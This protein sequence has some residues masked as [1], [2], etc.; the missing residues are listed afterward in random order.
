M[1]MPN[2]KK[3][4]HEK[5]KKSKHTQRDFS[6][7]PLV[8]TPSFQCREHEF[9]LWVISTILCSGFKIGYKAME[10]T[11]NINNVTGPGTANQ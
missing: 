4:K 2:Q 11:G 7:G 8:K 6:G 1:E 5:K 3:L 9:D 10:T